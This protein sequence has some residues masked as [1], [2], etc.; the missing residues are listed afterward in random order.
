M[1][2]SVTSRPRAY[3]EPPTRTSSGPLNGAT[4]STAHRRVGEQAERGEVAQQVALL[5]GDAADDRLVARLEAG[6]RPQ[7]LVDERAVLAGDGVAVRAG[8]RVAELLGEARL[9]LRAEDVL[10]LA[11][12]VVHGVPGHVEVV[13]EEPLAEAVAAHERGAFDRRRPR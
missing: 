8:E 12:L 4:L 7:V 10:E 2:L 6:E 13:D 1:I 3:C 11:G 9:D 5:L